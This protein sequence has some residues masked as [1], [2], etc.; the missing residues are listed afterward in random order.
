MLVK[1]LRYAKGS[2]VGDEHLELIQVLNNSSRAEALCS[3]YN[4]LALIDGIATYFRND[5]SCSGDGS[6]VG[7]RALDAL[8]DL[9][10]DPKLQQFLTSYESGSGDRSRAAWQVLG[11]QLLVTVSQTPD[12][13]TYFDGVQG[14]IDTLL[15]FL[16]AEEYDELRPKVEEVALV[17]KGLMNPD[18][19]NAILGPLKGVS[20]CL[21]DPSV[22]ANMDLV[23][24]LYDL[25]S[26]PSAESGLDLVELV[27]ALIGLADADREGVIMGLVHAVCASS[28][29][30][31]NAQDGMRRFFQDALT[32]ENARLALPALTTMVDR[33]V[34]AELFVL[35]DN[36][37]YGCRSPE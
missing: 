29:R 5:P 2:G 34:L 31:P 26:K 10:A 32:K 35:I 36:L 16:S 22:D 8:R 21:A 24:A 15:N 27:D 9:L 30:D 19:P 20:R 37:L 28:M 18:R 11:R 6:C 17:L 25:V 12:D 1:L 33:D 4:L 3:P 13:E 14:I 7:N 23:G